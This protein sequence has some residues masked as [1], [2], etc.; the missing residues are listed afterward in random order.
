MAQ[1]TIGGNENN[2]V[3]TVRRI[4][5]AYSL[6]IMTEH[7]LIGVRDPFGFRPLCLGRVGDA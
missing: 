3:Q 5:G 4:E 7:E 6:V 2:L 1:P